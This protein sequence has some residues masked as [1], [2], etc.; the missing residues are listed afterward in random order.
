MS[1]DFNVAQEFPSLVPDGTAS[2]RPSVPEEWIPLIRAGLQKIVEIQ[3]ASGTIVEISDIKEKFGHLSVLYDAGE[4]AEIEAI[5]DDLEALSDDVAI[6]KNLTNYQIL[7]LRDI[8]GDT[9]E[10]VVYNTA[11]ETALEKLI[12]LRL[13][14]EIS[15]HQLTDLGRQIVAITDEEEDQHRLRLIAALEKSL[16]KLKSSSDEDDFDELAEK[17]GQPQPES[18]VFFE[19][20]RKEGLGVGLRSDGS[21]VYQKDVNALELTEAQKDVLRQLDQPSP[22]FLWDAQA[23]VDVEVLVERE[24]AVFSHGHGNRPVITEAGRKV[25][26]LSA[27][28]PDLS[29]YVFARL[30]V[31]DFTYDPD[32]PDHVRIGSLFAELLDLQL[33]IHNYALNCD[34]IAGPEDAIDWLLDE[35]ERTRNR[36]PTHIRG[37]S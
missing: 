2:L 21:L 25:L 14:D 22:D 9:Q 36:A 3:N 7:V 20:R 34:C 32:N 35:L 12:E 8:A 33:R 37:G 31:D 19:E 28:L 17:L 6:Y 18:E 29:E 26:G 30:L 27:N 15:N 23:E 11:R 13:V 1:D 5:F 10:S 24:L 16:A 4:N